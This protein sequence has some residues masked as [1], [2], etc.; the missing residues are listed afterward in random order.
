MFADIYQQRATMATVVSEDGI[1]GSGSASS[2]IGIDDGKWHNKPFQTIA[3]S[4]GKSLRAELLKWLKKKDAKRRR[5]CTR[6]RVRERGRE[7][8]QSMKSMKK[9]LIKAS[10][11]LRLDN[12]LNIFTNG[13]VC[14]CELCTYV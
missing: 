1:R 9:R 12:H 8:N 10:T 6:V 5:E 3:K 4:G 2:R 11:Q 13:L 14:V 7:I